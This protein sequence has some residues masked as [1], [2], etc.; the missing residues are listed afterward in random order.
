MMINWLDTLLDYD[1]Q[2][3][4][5]PGIQNILPDALSRLFA[6]ENTLEGGKSTS[7][8]IITSRITRSNGSTMV[9][10]MMMPADLVTPA[11]EERQKLLLDTHLEGHRGAQA[12]VTALHSDGIHWTKLKE[13]ALE[14]V[15]QCPD[16]QKFNVAKHGFHPLTSIYADAPWDHICIDTA[17]PLPTSLQGNNYI[18][19]IV[20]VFTRYCVLKALPDK[21]S[22]T[23]AL[24]LRSV[25]S[26]FGR[27]KIIQSDNG[28]EYVNEIVRLYIESSGIDHR[29]ISA[30]HPRAN[31]IAERWVGKTKNILY[32]RL[33][34]K[35]E[36]WD[37]YLDSTQEA[38]NNTH[39]ALHSTRPF[40]LMFA[41][42][43]NEN[44]DYR[45]VLNKT[46]ASDSTKQLENRINEFNETVLPAIRERIKYSQTAAQ[47]KFNRS[48]RILTEIP[49]G[50]QVTL[51]N[52]NRTAKSDPLYVGNY[53]VKRKTQG[54]SYVLVDA[55][56]A[57]LPRDVP[58]SHIKAIS[59]ETPSTK[60]DQPESFEV[61]AVLHHK[62]TP[63][64]Y[65]Y[66]VRWKGYNEEDDTWEPASHFHDYTPIRKYWARRNEQEPSQEDNLVSK[67]PSPSKRKIGHRK[68]KASKKS[69]N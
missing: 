3:I 56:G 17:G 37:L 32:K 31:G 43:P 53:T 47:D 57:L 24:A 12:I 46:S 10:R 61:E 1:F 68:T 6:P 5:R 54:G 62:G 64:N 34:G 52:V 63:G 15:R 14:I 18:L 21:S 28:T 42:R 49:T 30:Y 51:K 65:L 33:Q 25:L 16:C 7:K 35:S 38:L 27:P 23:I 9:S 39:A 60:T 19:I 11:P 69:R 44:K 40:S 67:T 29:L 20:D 22:L 41:R 2:I 59:Q 4:H 58:P 8:T 55:T 50:S 66:R 26:L 48:H 13:D 36:D 45:S